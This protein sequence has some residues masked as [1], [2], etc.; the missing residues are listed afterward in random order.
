MRLSQV[1]KKAK[2]L[3]VKDAW[4]FPKKE[5]IKTIQRNEGNVD[6]FGARQSECN[7]LGCCWR[8]ECSKL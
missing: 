7:Q 5:L 4:R 2:T 8:N 1:Q 6:C 3:G